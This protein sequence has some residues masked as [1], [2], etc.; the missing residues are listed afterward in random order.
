MM[1]MKILRMMRVKVTFGSMRKRQKSLSG[2]TRSLN[3]FFLKRIRM[4][5]KGVLIILRRSFPMNFVS[6]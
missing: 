2:W 1:N 6:D 4:N 5:V 3:F